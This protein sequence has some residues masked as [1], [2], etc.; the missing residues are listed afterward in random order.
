MVFES[1]PKFDRVQDFLELTV[2]GVR[3]KHSFTVYNGG[4]LVSQLSCQTCTV[5]SLCE[6][7]KVVFSSSENILNEHAFKLVGSMRD[8]VNKIDITV[9]IIID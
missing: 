6:P 9:L 7:C 1:F 2:P 5:S 4:V 3:S 8:Q